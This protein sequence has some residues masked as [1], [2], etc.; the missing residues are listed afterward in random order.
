MS[1]QT[2]CHKVPTKFRTNIS[3][4]HS[5]SGT[6]AS[7][8]HPIL[9][10]HSIICDNPCSVGHWW[11]ILVDCWCKAT[12]GF[13]TALCLASLVRE[14]GLL[15]INNNGRDETRPWTEH[16]S[17]GWVPL[18]PTWHG[19]ARIF[20]DLFQDLTAL[21]FRWQVTCLSTTWHLWWLRQTQ[22]LPIQLSSS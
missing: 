14:Q 10:T 15:V 22:D 1:I 19:D 16:S 11:Y 6:K 7:K 12:Y 13:I 4:L 9:F 21:F 5:L 3:R 2:K 20:L 18:S 8:T 17:V